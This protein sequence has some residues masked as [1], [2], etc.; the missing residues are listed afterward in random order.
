MPLDASLFL[1]GAQLRAQQNANLMNTIATAGQ[2]YITDSRDRQKLLLSLSTPE[3]QAKNLEGY[4]A[5]SL[6]DALQGKQLDP[7][8]R[9]AAD[10]YARSQNK[11]AFDPTTGRAIIN[12][13]YGDILGKQGTAAPATGLDYGA[14]TA[15]AQTADATVPNGNPAPMPPVQ[16]QDA[17]I[18]PMGK[19]SGIA[20]DGAAPPYKPDMALANTPEGNAVAAAIPASA[21]GGTVPFAAKPLLYDNLQ[22]SKVQVPATPGDNPKAAQDALTDTNKAN[23]DLQKQK[24]G[25]DI[26]ASQTGAEKYSSTKGEAAANSELKD[27]SLGE[28]TDNIDRLILAS[29]GTPGSALEGAA[30]RVTTELGVPNTQALNASKFDVGKGIL[31]LQSRIAF[32][33]GQGS[34]SNQEAE[35][36]LSFLPGTNDPLE[37]KLNKLNAAKEYI[38]GL[39]SKSSA[40][41]SAAPGYKY[42]GV[43]K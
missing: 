20:L 15:P 3:A 42:L 12:N 19:P 27:Q 13:P 2:N 36:A 25:A 6:Y 14:L 11:P 23:I 38:N 22:A 9:A 1:Q 37:I 5:L 21:V 30:A 24:V 17:G 35:Q 29:K 28:L 31:G 10:F 18:D 26:A 43:K 16:R 8:A 32:L 33:K 40:V 39:K 7:Q 41:D 34:I 4:G